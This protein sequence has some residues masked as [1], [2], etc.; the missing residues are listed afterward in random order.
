MAQVTRYFAV[1]QQCIRN[2]IQLGAWPGGPT[3]LRFADDAYRSQWV[4]EHLAEMG[5]SEHVMWSVTADV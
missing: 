1:C 3:V 5:H 2:R 4:V